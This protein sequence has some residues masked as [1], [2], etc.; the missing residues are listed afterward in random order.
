MRSVY[1]TLLLSLLGCSSDFAPYSN[2]ST[3][4]VL[5]IRSDP[6]MPRADV[7]ARFEALTYVPVGVSATYQWSYCPVAAKA[8][9]RYACPLPWA[10]ASTVFGPTLP[11]YDLGTGPTATFTH[12]VDPATLASLCATGIATPDYAG[13]VDCDLGFPITVVLDLNTGV[14]PLRAAF[15]VY[16]PIDA[17]ATP[18]ANPG[19]EALYADGLPFPT[20]ALAATPEKPVVIAVATAPDAVEQRP[21]PAFEGT[22]GLRAE[23]LTFSWFT[24]AGSWDKDR[25]S[26]LDGETT[27]A[28]ATTNTWTA[29]AVDGFGAP[30][31]FYVVARDDRGGV[32]WI[33]RQVQLEIQP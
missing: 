28:E 1:P 29:P 10:T 8:A 20:Q 12:G 2:L 16:L 24:D 19:V 30:I 3:P 31:R 33:A 5:A 26:F 7:P 17:L 9:D 22:P 25:T 27:L 11:A 21:I 15:Q 13:S 4:R 14:Q 18:N 32:S 23:R 6:A